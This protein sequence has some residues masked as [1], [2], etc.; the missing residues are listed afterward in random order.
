[1]AANTLG[2]RL[3]VGFGFRRRCGNFVLLVVVFL[4]GVGSGQQVL[5]G[6]LVENQV[7]PVRGHGIGG[8]KSV[9]TDP[10][11]VQDGA[12]WNEEK[13]GSLWERF[14]SRSAGVGR[15]RGSEVKKR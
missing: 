11:V 1:M 14:P 15:I 3:G 12:V 13:T 5:K 4:D 6:L 9:Q 8:R 7:W 10:I 2:I